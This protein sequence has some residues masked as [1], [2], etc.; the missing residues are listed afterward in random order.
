MTD[1][2]FKVGGTA[3]IPIPSGVKQTRIPLLPQF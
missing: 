2:R 3:Q 1:N